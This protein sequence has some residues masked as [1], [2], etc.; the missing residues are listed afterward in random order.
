MLD[1]SL[2]KFESAGCKAVARTRM[3]AVE[4]RHIVLLGH[5]VDGGEEAQEVLLGVDVLFSVGT[6][7]DVSALLQA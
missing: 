4:D 1:Y 7:Q 5:P 3:A 6:Q 2:V